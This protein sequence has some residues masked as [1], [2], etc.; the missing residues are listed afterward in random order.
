MGIPILDDGGVRPRLP[1][2]FRFGAAGPP[3]GDVLYV[4]DTLTVF[5]IT[6]LD[7]DGVAIDLSGA[8]LYLVF[9]LD[10]GTPIDKGPL[11]VADD[12]TTGLAEYGLEDGDLDA[13]GVL[14]IRARIETSEGLCSSEPMLILIEGVV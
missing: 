14:T 11:M 3:T 5:A 7:A 10:G 4:G 6:C 9:Q 1:L 12:A 13:A 2:V 8:D